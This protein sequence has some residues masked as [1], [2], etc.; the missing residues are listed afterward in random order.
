MTTGQ[1]WG[2]TKTI[3][4]ELCHD[5]TYMAALD[6]VIYKVMKIKMDNLVITNH[7]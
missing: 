3:Q 5:T 1:Q 2:V 6:K 7:P 4:I